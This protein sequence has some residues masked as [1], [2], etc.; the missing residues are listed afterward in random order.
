MEW[1]SVEEDR[2]EGHNQMG[3]KKNAI[4][5]TRL[6]EIYRGDSEIKEKGLGWGLVNA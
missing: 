4:P 1:Y 6:P 5:Q 3:H 2:A